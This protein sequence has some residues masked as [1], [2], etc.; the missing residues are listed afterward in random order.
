MRRLVPIRGMTIGGAFLFA[1]LVLPSVAEACQLCFWSWVNPSRSYCR[2]VQ[3]QETGTTICTTY[4]DNLG[5]SDCS[6]S[7]DYCSVI[8]VTGG[9]GG[10]TGGAGDGGDACRAGGFCPAE[11]FSCGGTG[12]GGGRAV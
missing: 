9:G 10:G 4:T 6:E 8:T 1:L 7:G 5:G 12:S 11:C 3:N 2:P